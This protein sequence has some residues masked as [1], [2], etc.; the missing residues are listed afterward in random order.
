[1]NNHKFITFVKKLRTVYRRS[2]VQKLFESLATGIFYAEIMFL[3]VFGVHFLL[4]QKFESW[5]FAGLAMVIGLFSGLLIGLTE[6]VDLTDS[7]RRI[8]FRY[9]FKDRILTAL[10]IFGRGAA[11]SI[12]Q[13]QFN[14][15]TEHI[16][17]V[18]PKSVVR[19]CLPRDLFKAIFA[20]V[21]VVF[22]C[23]LLPFDH[24]HAET[25]TA[26]PNETIV[27]VIDQLQ[28]DV[29]KPLDELTRDNP[30]DASILEMNKNV[31]HLMKQLETVKS[32]P[33]ESL[34]TLSQMEKTIRQT[35]AEFNLDAI[36]ASLRDIAAA[37]ENAAATRKIATA[38][39]EGDYNKAA[40]EFEK[41]DLETI[42][43][44]ERNMVSNEL[45]KAS[46]MMERRKQ[47]EMAKL[48]QK[49]AEEIKRGNTEESKN[50][51]CQFAGICRKQ[52]LR[53]EACDKL[54]CQLAKLGL[55]KSQCAGACASCSKRNEC[56]SQ[57]SGETGSKQM[58]M[59]TGQSAGNLTD[60][61][62]DTR[63]ETNLDSIREMKQ[64]SGISGEGSSEIEAEK[65]LEHTETINSR[66]YNE[67]YKEFHKRAESILE[68]EPIPLGQRQ[69][70]RRYF[71]SIRPNDKK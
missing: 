23:I 60:G 53:K 47:V 10:K 38:I 55:C 19:Y 70:I 2:R 17:H 1:M 57:Q 31:Q 34:L 16:E 48:T 20:T 30:D 41:T 63:H 26:L 64:I 39:K 3:L 5:L 61:V 50:T 67:T 15:A 6:S 71:E 46:D 36:D 58:E 40:E 24:S 69:V 33:E 18:D 27:A 49:L 62:S 51:V 8:D 9:N 44:R 12:E 21:L 66:E 13:L 54:N 56:G 59:G 11:T 68:Q 7:A 25:S 14:D 4:G 22:C 65:S 28:E 32:S 42:S 45:T 43:Y 35:M 37:L 52:C 29:V